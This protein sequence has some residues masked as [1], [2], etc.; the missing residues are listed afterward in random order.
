MGLEFIGFL[1]ILLVGG[2]LAK[3]VQ[4]FSTDH[5]FVQWL[6]AMHPSLATHA[7]SIG[8]TAFG[9]VF[10]ITLLIPPILMFK[11]DGSGKSYM[12]GLGRGVA[13]VVGAIASALYLPSMA[14]LIGLGWFA[15]KHVIGQ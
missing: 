2:S 3:L 9:L 13:L 6:S 7:S 1:V 4:S 8:W 12:V 11:A 5:I 14:Y 15:A 10:V